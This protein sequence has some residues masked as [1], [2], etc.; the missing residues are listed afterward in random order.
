MTE[1]MS[2]NKLHDECWLIPFSRTKKASSIARAF[3]DDELPNIL[4]FGHHLGLDEKQFIPEL[5][6]KEAQGKIK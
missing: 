5:S 4:L 1:H 3:I 6:R 2:N